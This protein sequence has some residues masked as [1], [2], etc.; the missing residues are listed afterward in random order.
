MHVYIDF[1]EHNLVPLAPCIVVFPPIP[2]RPRS[3]QHQRA[4]SLS[5]TK[6]TS[7]PSDGTT[8]PA[9]RQR[10]REL[11]FVLP[12]KCDPWW[13]RFTE[14]TWPGVCVCVCVCVLIC[15][16]EIVLII[17][18][19]ISSYVLWIGNGYFVVDR[20]GAR[21]KDQ[22]SRGTACGVLLLSAPQ[23]REAT[24]R[25]TFKTICCLFIIPISCEALKACMD[26]VCVLDMWGEP[27]SPS[28]WH[29]TSQD[30]SYTTHLLHAWPLVSRSSRSHRSWCWCPPHQLW[31]PGMQAE[32]TS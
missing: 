32:P 18:T 21:A 27:I 13:T 26:L 20:G 12:D 8:Y 2:S 11:R 10:P 6:T 28:L 9:S 25:L 29:P 22:H 4:T 3:R 5:A 19:L 23:L 17:Y 14:C 16:K 15:W 1:S 7:I 24:V 31:R 30:W